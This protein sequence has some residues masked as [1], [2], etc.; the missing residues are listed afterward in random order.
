M[1]WRCELTGKTRQIGHRVSHSNR[2]TKRRFL[3]N[4]LNVTLISDALGRSVRLRISANAL[5]SVDHRG[6]LDAFLLAAK[7]DDLSPSGF[8]LTFFIHSLRKGPPGRAAG[9]AALA[10]VLRAQTTPC[11]PKSI[12]GRMLLEQFG[13]FFGHHATE[14]FC[15]HDR[16][17]APVITRNVMADADRD[18]FDR[19]AGF[20]LLD[21]P[22]QVA[23]E[24]VAGID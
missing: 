22:A 16:D 24:I 18:Q 8:G 4:L 3:P 1:A 19:R 11:R 7:D 10:A 5:K 17:G 21:H 13:E 14:F 15:V 12:V 2:K 20:D 23:F 9:C 6:G